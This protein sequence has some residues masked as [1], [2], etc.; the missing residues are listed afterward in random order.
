MVNQWLRFFLFLLLAHSSIGHV[1]NYQN[2]S[3]RLPTSEDLDA[4]VEVRDPKAP[5][6]ILNRLTGQRFIMVPD[7]GAV[8]GANREAQFRRVELESATAE[9]ISST[10]SV[11]TGNKQ[12]LKET[13]TSYPKEWGKFNT[14]LLLVQM[15][16]CFQGGMIGWADY[17]ASYNTPIC[18]D[19]IIHGLT[20][21][22]GNLGFM[23]FMY[24]N[25]LS[26]KHLTNLALASFE[27]ANMRQKTPQML[28]SLRPYIGYF[29]MGFGSLASDVVNQILSI[30]KFSECKNDVLRGNITSASCKDV[31][32]HFLS[33]EKF[34]VEFG[35]YLPGLV[36]SSVLAAETKKLITRVKVLSVKGVK[37][38]TPDMITNALK[39]AGKIRVVSNVVK[40]ASGP[41]GIVFMVAD[42]TFF[43]AWD[44]FLR[45]PSSKWYYKTLD[46]VNGWFGSGID[47]YATSI[48]NLTDIIKE[49]KG[50]SPETT[51]LRCVHTRAGKK[52]ENVE[53]LKTALENMS[54]Y[55]TRRRQ[56]VLHPELTEGVSAWASK[57]QMYIGTYLTGKVILE[58]V[59]V[60]RSQPKQEYPIDFIFNHISQLWEKTLR[61]YND[62]ADAAV[63]EKLKPLNKLYGEISEEIRKNGNIKAEKF[64]IFAKQ[65]VEFKKFMFSKSA[66]KETLYSDKKAP[67]D[68]RECHSVSWE[69][70]MA[71]YATLMIPDTYEQAIATRQKDNSENVFFLIDTQKEFPLQPVIRQLLCNNSKTMDTTQSGVLSSL[72]SYFFG[73]EGVSLD[74]KLPGL[75][76]DK[77]NDKPLEYLCG[78][79]AVGDALVPETKIIDGYEILQ[80]YAQVWPSRSGVEL[81]P[82]SLLS[83]K[84]LKL[85]SGETEQDSL[86]WWNTNI[87][88]QSIMVYVGVIKEY[89]KMVEANLFTLIDYSS[90]EELLKKEWGDSAKAQ[91]KKLYSKSIN[92]SLIG[93]MQILAESLKTISALTLTE[94]GEK[95]QFSAALNDMLLKY[96]EH[97][98]H[99]QYSDQFTKVDGA[100]EKQLQVLAANPEKIDMVSFSKQITTAT[101]GQ[102]F[103]A[104]SQR[105]NDLRTRINHLSKLMVGEDFGDVD[106]SKYQLIEA[107]AIPKMSR[108]E[109]EKYIVYNIIHQMSLLLVE[110]TRYYD[111]YLYLKSL[112][113][114]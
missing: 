113:S 28:H 14:G 102:D 88:P 110:T 34:W 71:L 69:I 32:T 53:Y 47:D 74:L 58:K 64:N 66:Y 93:Q 82:I 22:E 109:Y 18:V 27:L 94:T 101:F 87:L 13:I 83:N 61:P 21:V 5:E 38:V 92:L 3:T 99:F 1:S 84:N 90:S 23:A 67:L 44:H 39:A 72:Y 24:A 16:A 46:T 76:V 10:F 85:I 100:L 106:F 80:P 25:R 17:K 4:L 6:V 97:T 111:D 49:N 2:T 96:A 95:S 50:Y 36:A 105:H 70:C 19:N 29:G 89:K 60:N 86:K 26:S 8:D 52:C 68:N 48:K 41:V 81:E 9:D 31:A 77:K 40:L 79:W 42:I 12:I 65:V 75:V 78:Y 73:N 57:W 56:K 15:A 114:L 55:T 37:A 104:M 7:R 43:I 35:S 11:K 33:A 51:D 107:K 54:K 108:Q 62:A 63:Y 98:R 30:P 103:E 45:I 20:S 112:F 91:A 59:Y